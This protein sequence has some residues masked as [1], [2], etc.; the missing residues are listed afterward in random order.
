MKGIYIYDRRLDKSNL[1]GIDRKVLWQLEEFNQS[2]LNCELEVFNDSNENILQKIWT[3]LPYTDVKPTWEYSQKFNDIDFLYFRRTI[4]I[5]KNMLDFLKK[6]KSS[7]PKVKVIMEI[8]TYP[9]DGELKSSFSTYPYLLKDRINRLKLKGLVDRIAI[10]NDIDEV[11]GIKTLKFTN[12]IRVDE[13]SIREPIPH[14]GINICA[15]ASMEPWQGYERV[16]KSLNNY[17]QNQG[18]REIYL[19]LVGKGKELEYYKKLVDKYQLGKYIIFHGYLSGPDLDYIYNISD[20]A[21]DA[22]GRY[23]TSNPISTSLKSR[24]YLAKG[25]PVVSGSNSDLF[26]GEEKFYLEFP[27]EA[28]TFNFQEVVNFYDT[29]YENKDEEEV[30]KDIR[31]YAYE[32]CDFSK[33]FNNIIDYILS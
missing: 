31:N 28:T 32:V 33:F 3:R 4:A 24:E 16:I 29:L 13:I 18:N 14:D 12:G 26:T 15:V 23:K 2:I 25:I 10:Q 5:H 8:P 11:F 7:N 27:N 1:S 20:L 30:V 19:H 17:Y 9:Y 22:F 21:L 6:L